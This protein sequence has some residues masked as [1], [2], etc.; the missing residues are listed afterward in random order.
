MK[1]H[2]NEVATGILVLVSGAVLIGVLALLGTPGL[3]KPLNTYT[4]YYD[5]AGGIR[6]GAPVL[7]A[8]RE[9][10]KVSKMKSPIPPDKRP[11]GHP[12]DEVSIE[13]QVDSKAEVYQNAT[14]HL[15]QQTLMGQQ[16]ID[17]IHGDPAS[18]LAPNY[19][20]F[21]GERVPDLSE[22]VSNQV[23]Q[24]TGPGSDLAETLRNAH[25][26]MDT[27]N[28]SQ[29]KETIDNAEQMT[30]TLKREPW[31]LIWPSTKSYGDDKDKGSRSEKDKDKEK[32][33]PQAPRKSKSVSTKT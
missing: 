9:I 24:L 4:I 31:R 32:S 7:L 1:I 2:R 10:G 33:D 30:D 12:E 18:G 23:K 15:T 3:I 19:A 26:F 8:G 13:V 14:V 22:S 27:L 20:E 29:V 21:S 25:I 5:N 17:F 16:V 28:H 11:P 6:P